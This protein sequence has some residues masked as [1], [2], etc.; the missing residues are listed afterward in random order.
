MEGGLKNLMRKNV[1]D[2]KAGVE[3]YGYDFNDRM[4]G[5][6]FDKNSF[7]MPQPT[8]RIYGAP[9]KPE[10]APAGGGGGA[11]AGGG[12]GAAVPVPVPVAP[13]RLGPPRAEF[14]GKVRVR[15]GVVP[16]D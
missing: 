1:A 10:V 2:V 13:P 4:G 8:G 12:G 7:P 6:G 11:A 5:T 3:P 15:D 9:E 16:S 14:A